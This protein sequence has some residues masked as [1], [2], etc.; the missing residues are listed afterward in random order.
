MKTNITVHTIVKNE[1]RWV[2]Y[3]IMSVKDYVDKVLIYDTG[4]DDRTVEIIK[5]INDKKIIFE[6]KG[7]VDADGLTKLRQEQLDKTKTD[8]F[9]LVDG[10][11]IW[12]DET[13]IEFLTKIGS[14]DK[15]SWGVVIRAWNLIG[16]I[17]HHHPE[18][19][20]YH[21]PYAPKN[22]LGWANLRGFNKRRIQG[23]YIKGAYPQEAYY[24]S[25]NTP[26]Q[27]YG[28]KH[29]IFLENRYFHTSYLQRSSSRQNDKLTLNRTLKNKIEFGREFKT[30]NYPDVFYIKYPLP[31]ASPWQKRSL[32]YFIFALFITP[33]KKIK[34]RFVN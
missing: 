12:P 20:Y 8:W 23:L 27:N 31:V 25:T 3:A 26:I 16:D 13:I 5:T 22:Y 33:I 34:R 28:S 24:D 19:E 1:E 17:Y 6:Q 15:Q 10:D 7:K 30:A 21:W 2:W 4:S 29:L 32:I 11:E 14:S 18:S 9:L